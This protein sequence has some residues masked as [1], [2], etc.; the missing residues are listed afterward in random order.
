VLAEAILAGD[1]ASYVTRLAAHPIIADYRRVFR[2]REAASLFRRRHARSSGP[3]SEPPS[4][5]L[6]A[7]EA[8]HA[9]SAGFAWMFSGARVPAPRLV[10]LALAGAEW[11]L[12]RNQVAGEPGGVA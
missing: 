7:R 9:L 5:G 3:S 2:M 6:L 1:P 4:T 11:W 8:H 12:G 10:D